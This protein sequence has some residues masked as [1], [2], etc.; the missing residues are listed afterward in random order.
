[1]T[2]QR[3]L[4]KALAVF[5]LSAL[6]VDC[7]D[8]QPTAIV[9]AV[10]TEVAVPT[11]IDRMD[12]SVT[13]RNNEIEFFEAYDLK[14]GATVPATIT[15][16][17]HED[18]EPSDPIKVEI[19]AWSGGKSVLLRSAVLGFQEEKTKLLRM[20]L[21][22]PCYLFEDTCEEGESCIAGHCQKNA[23][24]V[25]S[26]PVF[27][28]TQ[29][30]GVRGDTTCFNDADTACLADRVSIPDLKKFADQGCVV[31][32]PQASNGNLNVAL[33]WT[34]AHDQTHLYVIDQ[35]DKEG[36]V[37]DGS[38][39]TRFKLSDNLCDE[40]KEGDVSKVAYS[41]AC[42]PKAPTTPVC[43]QKSQEKKLSTLN[44]ASPCTRC[45]YVPDKCNLE[46]YEG[47]VQAALNDE[48]SSPLLNCALSC[49]YDGHIDTQDECDGIDSCFSRCMA[50][51]NNCQG[52][53]CD[54]YKTLNNLATCLT[55][56]D[57]ADPTRCDS[58]CETE[59][60]PLC[61]SKTP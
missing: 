22:Y 5:A 48:I 19:T 57:G 6:T 60:I 39:K 37:F 21:R 59:N 16:Q 32:V 12:I 4:A 51:Y 35:D 56:I 14:S 26:L 54:K 2:T 43:A 47:V 61:K 15:L 9:V 24:S 31:D 55:D 7:A 13:R 29:V 45:V 1:M 11:E 3:F 17:P 10:S 8:K 28:T 25:E 33:L 41:V 30:F 40:I 34:K 50:P 44:E 36:W 23:I 52:S 18:E 46:E 49:P 38:S 20:P 42:K 53:E 58:L 27:E